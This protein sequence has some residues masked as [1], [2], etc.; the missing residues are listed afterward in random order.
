MEKL[1]DYLMQLPI[2]VI[3]L[4]YIEADDVIAYMSKVCFKNDVIICSSDKDFLQLVDDDGVKVL[5]LTKKKIYT[6]KEIEDEYGVSSKNFIHYKSIVGDVSDNIK[7]VNGI[8]EKTIRNKFTILREN[9]ILSFEDIY[10]FVE[11]SDEKML[12]KLLDQKDI[13]ERNHKLM[14]LH[15]VNISGINKS[16][17]RDLVSREVP[18]INKFKILN[19]LRDDGIMDNLEHNRFFT[20]FIRL[21]SLA[22]KYNEESGDF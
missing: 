11:T 6:T 21:D 16:K 3:A 8:G 2:T 14:Q 19:M 13:F 20:S 1:V 4:D 17:I 10:E 9:R 5:S 12:K 22:R 7:G 18:T 15:D